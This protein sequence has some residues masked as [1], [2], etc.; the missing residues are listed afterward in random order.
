MSA[1]KTIR[2]TA[3]HIEE[4]IPQDCEDCPIALAIVEQWDGPIN[5]HDIAVDNREVLVIQRHRGGQRSFTAQLPP[6]AMRFV[7]SFDD[8]Y[9]VE[10]FEFTV[11]WIDEDGVGV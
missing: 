8:G 7:Q 2:V 3:E 1:P 6:E 11:E 9:Q 10:P 4:G 5:H